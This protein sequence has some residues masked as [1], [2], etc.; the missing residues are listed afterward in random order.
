MSVLEIK[1]LTHK[2]KN[3]K[4]FDKLNISINKGTHITIL[5]GVGSGKTTLVKLIKQKHKA[6]KINGDYNIIYSNPLTQLVG[7]TV[8]E[9]LMFH[10]E[11]NNYSKRKITSR[12]KKIKTHFD[13]EP[14][15]D[16]DPFKLGTSFQQFI[17]ILSYLVLDNNIL[18]FD[19]AFNFLDDSQ[20]EQLFKYLKTLKSTIIC[21]SSNSFDSLFGDEL[22]IMNKKIIFRGPIKTV[23]DSDKVFNQN[24]L[25]MPFMAD[26]S[27]KLQY[28]EIIDRIILDMDE[29]V[30][31]IWK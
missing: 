8:K 25:N 22:A 17:V 21:L 27:L 18:I 10:M 1:N 11:I 16:Q 15:I 6:I 9:Q 30:D 26:L 5:G 23:F 4:V 13:I 14:F 28:Y 29:A 7:K 3:N 2:Y 19:N 12:I 31:E 20:K 24:G